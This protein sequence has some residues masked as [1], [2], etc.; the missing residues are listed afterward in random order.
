[1]NRDPICALCTPPGKGALAVIRLTGTGTQ[2]IVR[3]I[4]PF[5]P[6]KLTGRKS[7]VGE[8]KDKDQAIDQV[9]LTYFAE[10]S[11]F[12]GEETVEISC[13]G[14]E[15]IY[16]EILKL[17]V[18]AGARPAKRGEFSFR[19]FMNGKMDLIQAEGL[20]QLIESQNHQAR[21]TAFYQLKGRFSKELGRLEKK[22]LKALTLLEADID[23]PLEGLGALA[24]SDVKRLLKELEIEV[25]GILS[26]Y[27]PFESLQ[28]GFTA[29]L[30]GPAN[31]GKSTLF[32][33]LIGEDK[34]IVT[35]TAGTTRD[36]VEGILQASSIALKDTAG[37]HRA[38][39]E[40]EKIGQR[41]AKE[42]FGQVD[43]CLLILDGAA[44][45]PFDLQIFEETFQ[46]GLV[47]WTKKD[48]CPKLTGKKLLSQARARCPEIFGKVSLNETFFVSSLTGEGLTDLREKLLFLNK[49]QDV[50][51]SNLRHFKSLK[52]MKKTLS[53]ALTLLEKETGERDLISLEV[54]EGLLAL[55][56]ITGRQ[57]DDRILDSIFKQF[58]IG[59]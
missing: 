14:G 32:N 40:V 2:Q 28:K 59:K 13:H 47:V 25:R 4:A 21:K 15:L 7:Y 45:F 46:K 20:L 37:F 24:L 54:R 9:V 5:L 41:K 51:V 53:R 19:S 35:E 57:L 27:R 55:Y 43:L 11:S 50:L 16:G 48:L 8:I 18:S 26:R 22:L 23:F 52:A 49:E 34:S 29:G 42:L 58:C 36:V 56:E 33:R 10:G 31:A 44:P 12:T 1:M 17:L 3:T 30:F 39:E 38:E 6:E